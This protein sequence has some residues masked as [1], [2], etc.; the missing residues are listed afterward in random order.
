MYEGKAITDTCTNTKNM[1]SE[2]LGYEK[3]QPR[4]A[5]PGKHFATSTVHKLAERLGIGNLG[6]GLIKPAEANRTVICNPATSVN[7]LNFTD[8]KLKKKSKKKKKNNDEKNERT[9]TSQKEDSEE[10]NNNN[11]DTGGKKKKSKKKKKDKKEKRKAKQKERELAKNVKDENETVDSSK[12][13]IELNPGKKLK[14]S[15]ASETEKKAKTSTK[16]DKI[17]G[18]ER[19]DEKKTFERSRANFRKKIMKRSSLDGQGDN[20]NSKKSK[21]S[22][23]LKRQKERDVE[24]RRKKKKQAEE[25]DAKKR[26]RRSMLDELR[27]SDGYVAEKRFK[28]H[29]DL[30]ADPSQLGREERALQVK[31]IKPRYITAMTAQHDESERSHF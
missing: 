11:T 24:E 21:I 10:N 19:R 7:H 2:E 27:N 4:L 30:F 3:V 5:S 20:K 14:A 6:N 26:K 12:Y 25:A 18:K 28:K 9:S 15:N 22:Q 1:T 13:E 17:K 16:R 31:K 8:G 29:E 23:I